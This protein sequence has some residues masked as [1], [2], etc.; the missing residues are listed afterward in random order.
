MDDRQNQ[1]AHRAFRV[2]I[3]SGGVSTNAFEVL[4][5]VTHA[6]VL[7][8]GFGGVFGV[9]PLARGRRSGYG[10]LLMALSM[11]L[12]VMEPR[13]QLGIVGALVYTAAFMTALWLLLG[14]N[15][16]D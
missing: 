12:V 7:V 3:V 8:L 1:Q 13:W 2:R 10:L 4:G 11:A 15:K 14:P 5:L 16:A 9:I 6:F